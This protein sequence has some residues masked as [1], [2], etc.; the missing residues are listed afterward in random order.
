MIDQYDLT[1]NVFAFIIIISATK[2]IKY[3]LHVI[4]K[5]KIV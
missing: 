1:N 4:N 5:K 3:M 2:F